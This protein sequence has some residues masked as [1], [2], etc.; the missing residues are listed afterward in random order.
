MNVIHEPMFLAAQLAVMLAAFPVVEPALAQNYGFWAPVINALRAIGMGAAG[1][2]LIVAILIKGSAA[3]N[4]DRH[5][6]AAQV[7]ERV[8]AGLFLIL[9]GW[10]IYDKIVAWTPF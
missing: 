7:A 3:T 2:G 5:A 8:F 9:L 6:L 1:V 4:A 10:F